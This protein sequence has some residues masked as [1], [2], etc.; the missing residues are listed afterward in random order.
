MVPSAEPTIA[1]VWIQA[2]EL[3]P[4]LLWESVTV[5]RRCVDDEP[6]TAAV[7]AVEDVDGHSTT[8]AD[9]VAVVTPAPTHHPLAPLLAL[10]DAH[11]LTI[12]GAKVPLAAAEYSLK[13][14]GMAVLDNGPGLLFVIKA[15]AFPA[16]KLPTILRAVDACPLAHLSLVCDP[17]PYYLERVFWALGTRGP[18]RSLMFLHEP[19]ATHVPP[20]VEFLKS[21]RSFGLESLVMSGR[22]LTAADLSAIVDAV[23]DFNPTLSAVNMCECKSKRLA[24][25]ACHGLGDDGEAWDRQ[26]RRLAV[27]LERNAILTKRVRR[28]AVRSLVLARVVAGGR[29]VGGVANGSAGDEVNGANGSVA[30]RT[31]NDIHKAATNGAGADA[32]AHTRAA[33]FPL[34][35]LPPHLRANIIRH[36]SADPLALT[37]EQWSK[38]LSH[39][40]DPASLGRL[41]AGVCEARTAGITFPL[42]LGEWLGNGGFWWKHRVPVAWRDWTV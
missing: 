35:E 10:V 3:R 17:H 42:A 26:V 34:L 14:E 37:D 6:V 4:S 1:N 31:G 18:P 32:D 39:V 33:P 28:A 5:E 7:A 22:S 13:V 20:I 2:A 29:S 38:L 19:E 36:A 40:E 16:F 24:S 15:W 41:A 27:Y 9:E 23:R 12:L 21:P 11:P 30:N 25:C 8:A